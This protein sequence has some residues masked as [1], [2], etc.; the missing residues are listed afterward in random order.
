M[1]SDFLSD[2]PF[3]AAFDCAARDLLDAGLISYDP[4]QD[5]LLMSPGIVQYGCKELFVLWS[6]V[7]QN[8]LASIESFWTQLFHSLKTAN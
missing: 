2:S 5:L 1:N 4:H 7:P 3:T 8:S 6:S